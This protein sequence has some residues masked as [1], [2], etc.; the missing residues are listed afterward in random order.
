MR[1][2]VCH[3]FVRAVGKPS[4]NLSSMQQENSRGAHLNSH[5]D[6]KKKA[7]SNNLRRNDTKW[8]ERFKLEGR[9]R[10]VWSINLLRQPWIHVYSS[11]YVKYNKY[12]TKQ[13]LNLHNWIERFKN[14][15][16]Q[17]WHKNSSCMVFISDQV[18]DESKTLSLA[19]Y[20]KR[21]P[22]GW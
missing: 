9:V 7:K 10:K 17:K 2:L 22:Y 15:N 1:H 11:T 8:H 14:V 18:L 19:A 5:V 3:S 12:V 4:N 21:S 13:G 20:R 6:S 16:Y